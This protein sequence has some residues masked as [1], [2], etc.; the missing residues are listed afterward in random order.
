MSGVY[1]PGKEHELF[2]PSRTMGP[3]QGF[4]R[5]RTIGPELGLRVSYLPLRFLGVE[6]EG[7]AMPTRTDNDVNATIFA[8]R[9]GVLAQ[10]PFW[11]VTPFVVVGGGML[12]V[13]SQRA[14]VGND[15]DPSAYFGGGLKINFNRRIQL[16]LDVRDVMSNKRGVDNTFG[17]HNL[18]VLVSFVLTFGRPKPA[19]APPRDT[20]SN[21]IS[22]CVDEC[23]D[24]PRRGRVA[25]LPDRTRGGATSTACSPLLWPMMPN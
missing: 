15:I 25:R 1:V 5:F 18:E 2:E 8:F 10:L 14:A 22:I 20:D 4:R 13:A 16:R 3:D 11:S 17:N 12:G 19:G 23:K 21:G 6:L 24:V 9:G 7:A